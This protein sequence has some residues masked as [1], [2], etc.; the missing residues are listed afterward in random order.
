MDYNNSK[1]QLCLFVI[2]FHRATLKHFCL[3][4]AI[5]AIRLGSTAIGIQSNEGVVSVVERRVQ[6]KLMEPTVT[7]K[8]VEI[9]TH[10]GCASSGL[11]ADSRSMIDRAR[12]A[13]S[14][15]WFLYNE[16]MSVESITQAVSNLAI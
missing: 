6:S 14:N 9:D 13:T 10:C 5:K 15:H 7:D 12:V 16:K 3:E 2:V 8:I 11:M 4:Y 1:P